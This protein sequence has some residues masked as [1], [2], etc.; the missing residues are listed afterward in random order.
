MAAVA[1]EPNATPTKVCPAWLL[2]H[3]PVMLPIPGTSSIAHL[4]ENTAAAG[5]V[6][7]PG[8]RARLDGI[9]GV[10]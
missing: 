10:A 1:A 4:E 5:L 2:N 7:T 9:A 8:L 6:L 3:S